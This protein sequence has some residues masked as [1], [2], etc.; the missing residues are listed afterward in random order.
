MTTLDDLKRAIDRVV[1]YRKEPLMVQL[2]CSIG[3]TA[4]ERDAWRSAFKWH[5]WLLERNSA[6]LETVNAHITDH[7]ALDREEE[8]GMA[9]IREKLK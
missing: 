2:A 6:I 1:E 4:A 9:L 3:F 5:A 8:E 7:I